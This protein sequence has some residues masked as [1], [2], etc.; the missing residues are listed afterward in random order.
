MTADDQMYLEHIAERIARIEAYTADGRPVFDA[1]ELI[2]DGVIRSFEVIGEA[3]KRLSE[4]LREREPD[5]R[6]REIAGF[7]DVLI[8]NYLGVD[9]NL[10]WSTVE[11]SVPALKAAIQRIREA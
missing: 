3:V 6:W 8:H 10:V 9:L 5:V 11:T 1:S 7:R 2:Q 4:E